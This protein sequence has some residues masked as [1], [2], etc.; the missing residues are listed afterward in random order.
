M[1]TRDPRT[2][3]LG[4]PGKGGGLVRWAVKR[5]AWLDRAWQPAKV[6]SGAGDESNGAR[7]EIGKR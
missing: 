1:T 6:D 5:L 4:D 2:G 7:Q 3:S